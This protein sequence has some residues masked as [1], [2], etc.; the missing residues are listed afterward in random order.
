MLWD[1]CSYTDANER[2]GVSLEC[3]PALVGFSLW[4]HTQDTGEK[5][6][7]LATK[8]LRII[9]HACSAGERAKAGAGA[10]MRSIL[11]H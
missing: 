2:S 5:P 1:K 4:A 7:T 11:A 6:L 9:K 8:G 10:G 3:L